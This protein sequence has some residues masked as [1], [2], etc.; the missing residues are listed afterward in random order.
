M[1]CQ[2]GLPSASRGDTRLKLSSLVQRSE[3]HPDA[4]AL[5]ARQQTA[6]I[7]KNTGDASTRGE[8]LGRCGC[9]STRRRPGV[10]AFLINMHDRLIPCVAICLLHTMKHFVSL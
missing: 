4:V 3:I 7:A 9:Q 5:Q 10:C 2:R 8:E 6:V 1:R